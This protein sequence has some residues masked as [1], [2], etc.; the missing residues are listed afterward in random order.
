MPQ[1]R[2]NDIPR[3]RTFET[4]IESR[5]KSGISPSEMVA[6]RETFIEAESKKN[7]K[8]IITIAVL[9]LVG[10]GVAFGFFKYFAK[11]ESAVKETP[12]TTQIGKPFIKADLEKAVTDSPSLISAIKQELA[13]PRKLDS[14]LFFLTPYTLKE[15]GELA[16]I[17]IP[18]LLIQSAHPSFNIFIAYSIESS[19]VVLLIKTEDFEKTYSLLLSWEKDMWQSFVP[20]LNA[21]DITN[22][23]QFSFGDE[24]IRNNDSRVLKNSNNKS[25]IAYSIF[26]KEFVVIAT[27]RE[28]LSLVLRR[29]IASPP[30]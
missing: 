14:L 6:K 11:T 23:K 26:N 30:K 17:K 19:S 12:K 15:F 4:D 27:S 18:E 21:E 7:I 3:I 28:G 29:L 13:I 25:I 20:F 16:N 24:I 8:K 5:K 22:I 1:D 9:V 2:Q 10:G